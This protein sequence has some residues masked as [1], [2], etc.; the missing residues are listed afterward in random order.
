VLSVHCLRY[1]LFT[2]LSSPNLACYE[3]QNFSQKLSVLSKNK[4]PPRP[5]ILSLSWHVIPSPFPRSYEY[6]H[7]CVSFVARGQWQKF[8]FRLDK[9]SVRYNL[10]YFPLRLV[11]HA[12]WKFRQ[13]SM[14]LMIMTL[15][16]AK[17]SAKFRIRQR[18]AFGD[19][20]R[21]RTPS[22]LKKFSPRPRMRNRP[23]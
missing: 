10:Q 1:I 18:N 4:L 22:G 15:A 11:L 3:P 12:K 13:Q 2:T 19:F 23:S 8:L 7:M 9:V 6:P 17:S 21:W 14:A 20:A 16:S 5:V